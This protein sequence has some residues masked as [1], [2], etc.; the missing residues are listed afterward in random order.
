MKSVRLKFIA[1]SLLSAGLLS[2]GFLFPH[3]GAFVLFSLLPLLWMDSEAS[4]LGMKHFWPWHYLTFVLWNTFTTFWVCNATVGGGIFAVLANAMQMSVIWA[5]FRA[6]KKKFGGSLPYIFLATM[7]IAWE[8]FYFDAEISWPWLVLGNAFAGTTTAVQ[9]YEYTGALG[10][11]LWVWTCN[12]SLFGLLSAFKSGSWQGLNEKARRY[13][14]A[15][16]ALAFIVPPALS[17][18]MYTHYDEKSDKGSISTVVLQPNIDP[19][20]KFVS[21]TQAQQNDLLCDQIREQL[22][23][24]HEKDML[25]VAPETFTSD[26]CVDDINSSATV[27]QLKGTISDYPGCNII[28]GA[29]A[30]SFRQSESAPTPTAR[31]IGHS[32]WYESYNAGLLL[33]RRSKAGL[34][35]KSR[36]VV[37]VEKMPYPRFFSKID[38]MLGGVMGRCLG[39]KETSLLNFVPASQDK[40]STALGCAIC[41]ESIYPEHFASFVK[42]GAVAMTVITNDAWWGDTPGY[43]QHLNYSRLRAIE[44]RRC[45]A[46]SANTG[47]SAFI[48]QRGDVISQSHWWQK[49]TLA[50]DLVC[51]SFLTVFVRYGDIC[52][53]LCSF[54]FLLLGL[55][56]TV[57]LLTGLRRS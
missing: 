55:A 50:S 16:T 14:L 3:C 40:E 51:S 45:I 6:F 23:Q 21:M 32:T 1:A 15:A 4:R 37:G 31:R 18:F 9:W 20:N 28:V 30:Y 35:K 53:R 48:D 17:M 44:T 36:L 29:S 38:N 49:E 7:W 34:Y 57:R 46:R 25:F 54:V 52:G 43:R 13:A 56:F 22:P 12:L 41:Y 2:A 5:L 10:G 33:S 11:S 47:I 39:Q 42:K 27:Q 26:V 8:R 19:Y 24:D